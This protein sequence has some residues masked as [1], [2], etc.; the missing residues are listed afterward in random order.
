MTML[1]GLVMLAEISAA[2]HANGNDMHGGEDDSLGLSVS[3]Q[4]S[5]IGASVGGFSEGKG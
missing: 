1:V 3:G 4:Y 5:R 2:E